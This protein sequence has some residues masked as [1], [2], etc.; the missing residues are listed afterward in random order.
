MSPVKVPHCDECW[1]QAYALV[2]AYPERVWKI[3]E[4]PAGLF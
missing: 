2:K 1:E 3:L 4:Q